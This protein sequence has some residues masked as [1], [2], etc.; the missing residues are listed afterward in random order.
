[1]GCPTNL[2]KLLAKRKRKVIRLLILTQ[3][4][5][6][7]QMG[8]HLLVIGEETSEVKGLTIFIQVLLHI[9]SNRLM[10]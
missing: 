2:Y 3:E 9:L 1:M 8:N 4:L 6:V 7:D 5:L 10:A